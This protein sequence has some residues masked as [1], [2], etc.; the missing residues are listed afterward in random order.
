MVP[1]IEKLKG[2]YFLDEQYTHRGERWYRS[3]FPLRAVQSW[4][5]RSAGGRVVVGEASPY[6]L[7]HPHAPSR[8]RTVCPDAL[9]VVLLR[10]PVER[11]FS[12]WKERRKNGTEP[13]EFLDALLAEPERLAG[14]EERLRWD[15]S[16]VSFPH[17]HQ[18][19]IAQS[20]YSGP[21]R[22]WIASGGRDSVLVWVL[23]EVR[24]DWG[25]YLDEF[26]DRLGLPGME[27]STK[28]VHNAEPSEPMAADA[29][30][31]LESEL[32]ADVA[33]LEELLGRELPWTLSRSR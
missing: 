19:Y 7:F 5:G 6:Y 4:R 33:A 12:H 29:R 10:D 18:S 26:F 8:A 2:T 24:L 30:A 14:E 3:H 13:L 21:L 16:H 17:R 20:R 25:R 23:E 15:P 9:R 27:I 1:R 28:M 31:L 32:S 11:A 22:R